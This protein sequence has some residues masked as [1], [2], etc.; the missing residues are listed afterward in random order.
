MQ[1]ITLYVKKWGGIVGL[2]LLGICAILAL[3]YAIIQRAS[4]S[5]SVPQQTDSRL[6]VPM[7]TGIADVD[8]MFEGLQYEHITSAPASVCSEVRKVCYEGKTV[9]VK[10]NYPTMEKFQKVADNLDKLGWLLDDGTRPATLLEGLADDTEVGQSSYNIFHLLSLDVNGKEVIYR[11]E[12][13]AFFYPFG[14]EL[15]ESETAGTA[16]QHLVDGI[17]G[18]L[19]LSL[20][21]AVDKLDSYS[22]ALAITLGT[23]KPQ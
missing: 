12:Q 9:I 14:L 5:T 13:G 1:L 20:E 4:S 2:A 22:F 3:G 21:N 19:D 6:V 7:P 11:G 15:D 8:A 17:P 18:A 16:A 10:M 23:V